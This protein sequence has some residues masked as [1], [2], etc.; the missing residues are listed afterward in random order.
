MGIP[1]F[2]RWT[3]ERYP[4][5]SKTIQN[6]EIPEFD[7]LYLDMNGII[8]NCSH[9]NDEDPNF[10]ITE[11]HIFKAVM[12]YI[13]GLFKIIRPKKLFYMAVDGVAP[14]AKMNQQRARR[15]RS[16]KEAELALKMA[17]RKGTYKE[18]DDE[19]RFD[20]NCITPGTPFM[21]RL[22][23]HLEYFVHWKLTTDMLWRNVEVILDGHECPGEGEHKI[24]DYIRMKKS[25]AGY[26]PNTRH[27]M[28]GLDA[29][30]MILGLL[31]H[32]PYFFL[33]REEVQF[34]RSKKVKKEL[35][36]VEQKTW[37]LLSLTL[38]R[39]YLDA[40]FSNLAPQLRFEYDFERVLDDWVLLGFFVG[41]DFLPHL[42]DFHINEDIKPYIYACYKRVIVTLDGWITD[43]GVINMPRLQVLLDEIG[44]FDLQRFDDNYADLKWM[45]SKTG[46]H[47][48][49][50]KARRKKGKGAATPAEGSGG[51]DATFGA[52]SGGEADFVNAALPSFF[53]GSDAVVETPE[54]STADG[55]EDPGTYAM[56][57]EA[58]KH[59]YYREKLHVDVVD[60]AFVDDMARRYVVGLQWVLLYYFKGTPAWGWFFDSH[61]APF[62]SDLK[63]IANLDVKFELGK[64][65]LPFEQLMAVL[66]P[67]SRQHVP[68]CM[69][70]LMT[71]EDSPLADFYPLEFATDLNGKKQEWEALVLISFIDEKRL[72][73]AMATHMHELTEGEIRRNV[74][75]VPVDFVYDGTHPRR[76]A[77]PDPRAFPTLEAAAVRSHVLTWPHCPPDRQ[78]KLLCDG[79]NLSSYTPGYPTLKTLAYTVQLKKAGVQVF[80][81]PSTGDSVV[82]S[83]QNGFT[84]P[85]KSMSLS[86]ATRCVAGK[87]A[88]IEWPHLKECMVVAIS[89]AAGRC[90][91]AKSSGKG[92]A[93]AVTKHNPRLGQAWATTARDLSTTLFKSKGIAVGDVTHIAHVRRLQ[94]VRTKYKQSGKAVVEKVWA[95]DETCVP[96]D[97]VAFDI[98]VNESTAV[99]SIARRFP[100]GTPVCYVGHEYRGAVGKVTGVDDEDQTLTLSLDVHAFP[101]VKQAISACPQQTEQYLPLHTAAR[102][103][104]MPTGVMGRLLSSYY[105][106]H[107]SASNP[108]SG[109][110]TDL[111]L[112][113]KFNRRQEE[114]LGYTR[115]EPDGQWQVTHATIAILTEYKRR[116]PQVFKIFT[117]LSNHR[118]DILLSEMFPSG[119]GAEQLAPVKEWLRSLPTNELSTVPGG[120]HSLSAVCIQA[121]ERVQQQ[122]LSPCKTVVLPRVAPHLVYVI[123]GSPPPPARTALALGDRVVNVDITSGIPIGAHGNI[124]S[125]LGADHSNA[126]VVFDEPFLGGGTLGHRCSAGRG[127]Q[128]RLTSLITVNNASAH[129]AQQSGTVPGNATAWTGTPPDAAPADHAAG[130]R[131]LGMLMGMGTP[132]DTP[133]Q[134]P[135]PTG[136]APRASNASA[137]LIDAPGTAHIPQPIPPP[138][139]A[140]H[141]VAPGAPVGIEGVARASRVP[142]ELG[143]NVVIDVAR[144]P[145]RPSAN[146]FPPRRPSKQGAGNASALDEH[147]NLDEFA[148]M[149]REL[150]TA[151]AQTVAIVPTRQGQRPSTTTAPATASPSSNAS[152]GLQPSQQGRGKKG[153]SRGGRK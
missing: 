93:F 28:Y 65:F 143:G 137:A 142:M 82:L 7:N 57:F 13:E 153:R 148:D 38:F 52:P 51:D 120:S 22:Q 83:L 70:P 60:Q 12:K 136:I 2:Y 19:G 69:Q 146:A 16:A 130:K 101:Q 91:V 43:G 79:V 39:D 134:L 25:S 100:T 11:A 109:G 48:H 87:R 140:A 126:H 106:F 31:S 75:S 89:D 77:S 5:L 10:R 139:L 54:V 111:G 4:C 90:N 116:F 103:V 88:W 76:Y 85:L 147:V 36:G 151:H 95:L 9:P 121:V 119:D 24:L 35:D 40:E 58:H 145:S 135:L 107:G 49:G 152:Q 86:E 1:K 99:Q 56:E 123:D 104:G 27:C 53:G 84:T 81:R 30:L 17:I 74:H 47:G 23:E 73:A 33:L 122:A 108:N 144:Q 113:L 8:H 102:I 80:Q 124:V 59:G 66:P 128:V 3:S 114:M 129:V 64:P 61:Y 127:S 125:L 55:G 20:S 117:A 112:K 118:G 96:L 44:K 78:H 115:L 133:P 37:H 34:G 149:W 32:E 29:D 18:G 42:P 131:L 68:Q 138:R 67:A 97:T 94:S 105:V 46:K 14:R 50:K 71:E 92:A 21:C 26:N 110:K 15:F 72:L 150:Q 62:C 132:T 63:N 98:P 41:N 141:E 6:D 45:A